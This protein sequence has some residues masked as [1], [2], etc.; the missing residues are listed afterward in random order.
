MGIFD[1]FRPKTKPAAAPASQHK[2][3]GP[4]LSI[5]A[6]RP[7]STRAEDRFDRA[8]FA[9]Q[10]ANIIVR[11]SDP[12]SLVV[13][14]YGPWGDG[15]TSV[16]QLIQEALAGN[17]DV[18]SMTYNP[19]FYGA[20]TEAITKSFFQS[21]GEALEKTGWFTK[22]N[23][24]TL[25]ARFGKAIP[26][27]GEAVAAYGE[28][29]SSESLIEA[30]DKIGEVLK[31]HG[32]KVVVFVDDID[33][34]D[35]ADI[36]TLFKLVRLSGDFDHTTYVLAFDDV[37]VAEALGEAYGSGD[38][39]A[40]RRFL[41][42]IVQAPLHLPPAKPETLRT[43]L[44]ACCDRAMR[45]SDLILV[46]GEQYE[47]A[48]NLVS[49]FGEVLRTP[50]QVKLFDNALTFA[51]PMLK[52]EVRIVDQIL[53]EGLRV[54]YPAVY[55]AVRQNPQALLHDNR[56]HFGPPAPPNPVQAVIDALP[57]DEPQKSRIEDLITHL[58]PRTGTMGYGS[59]WDTRWNIEKRV[60]SRDYFHRYFTYAVPTGDLS[61]Q[62]VDA[63]VEDATQ[64][65][66]E[67]VG[68]AVDKALERSA[69]EVL[70]RKLRLR[71][72]LIP[73][74]A[75]PV[76]ASALADRGD[77][78][79]RSG[80][81]L[82][83]DWVF[84]QAAILVAHLVS[85]LDQAGQDAVLDRLARSTLAIPF[86]IEVLRFAGARR[87]EEG[88]PRGFIEADRQ[89]RLLGLVAEAVVGLAAPFE[90][91]GDRF[92]QV[93]FAVTRG[94]GATAETVVKQ[95]LAA[96]LAHDP[97]NASR[98]LRA[99]TVVA[100][101]MESGIPSVSDFDQGAYNSLASLLDPGA[102]DARL[103]EIHGQALD[104][105]AYERDPDIDVDLRLARQFSWLHRH[106]PSEVETSG[107][108]EDA[109]DD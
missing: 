25:V 46:E 100:W 94:G 61:D 87:D 91:L 32:K 92:S 40:G 71:E 93:M 66:V 42:K 15:K 85:R 6:D 79:P 58:F 41:E 34:L 54:F 3:A 69:A 74:A 45:E 26:H 96:L 84:R 37:I 95:R 106:P 57:L 9:G 48:N 53:I 10:V 83:G 1:R 64:G 101:G 14:V 73:A 13:G 17:D 5:Q 78:L 107:I 16:L 67:A 102:L 4:G 75:A 86:V 68:L 98:F 24:A 62:T 12:S 18:V 39:A 47:L 59:E 80:E 105:D 55:Q 27:V 109:T 38:I 23:V 76:L 70:I 31:K 81:P 72:D 33:R 8:P 104:A 56:N 2:A 108:T 89:Q 65:A 99:V 22:E 88:Q 97:A 35:R 43:M 36:Q 60:C 30:R 82:V 29:I 50:R 7:I 77:R 19:W 44:F 11:R 103:S 52:G 51:V 90:T 63:I 28:A 49:A 20:S 21:L